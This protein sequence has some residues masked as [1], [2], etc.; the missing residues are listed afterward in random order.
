VQDKVPDGPPSDEQIMER[1]GRLTTEDGNSLVKGHQRQMLA[2]IK[3]LWDKKVGEPRKERIAESLS[4]WNLTGI[5]PKRFERPKVLLET[6][7]VEP[8]E[9]PSEIEQVRQAEI[10]EH[11]PEQR[12]E[13]GLTSEGPRA[14]PGF[15]RGQEMTERM[16]ARTWQQALEQGGVIWAQLGGKLRWWYGDVEHSELF[17]DMRIPR[18]KQ[19]EVPRGRVSAAGTAQT[20]ETTVKL[21]H[22]GHEEF[23]PEEVVRNLRGKLGEGYTFRDVPEPGLRDVWKGFEDVD[24]QAKAGEAAVRASIPDSEHELLESNPVG[25]IGVRTRRVGIK[26]SKAEMDRLVQGAGGLTYRP[27]ALG[28]VLNKLNLLLGLTSKEHG[29]FLRELREQP[30]HVY[31]PK[32]TPEE[33]EGQDEGVYESAVAA[34]RDT[35]YHEGLHVDFYHVDTA[36]TLVR[37]TRAALGDVAQRLKRFEVYRN[38]SE[39][40]MNEEAFVHVATAI[41]TGNV[42]GLSEYVRMDGTPE[43]LFAAVHGVAEDLREA[44]KWEADDNMPARV[45]SRK[46]DDL[47][48]RTDIRQNQHYE[49]KMA[50]NDE[51]AEH[52]YDPNVD[53]WFRKTPQ[54][55]QAER[56]LKALFDQT[57]EN[58]RAHDY[59]PSASNWAEARGVRGPIN[60]RNSGPVKEPENVD[61]PFEAIN[62][63]RE[64]IEPEGPE[65][66]EGPRAAPRPPDQP[67][68]PPKTRW[69]GWTA[70]SSLFRPTGPWVADLDKAVNTALSKHGMKIPIFDRFKDVDEARA[71]RDRWLEP[72]YDRVASILK[73][74]T[75]QQQYAYFEV[76][77]HP[78]QFHAQVGAKLGLAVEDMQRVKL[79]DDWME[80]LQNEQ[81][82]IRIKAYLRDQLPRLRG[83]NYDLDRVYGPAGKDPSKMST[84][85]RLIRKER[86]DPKSRHIGNLIDRALNEAGDQKFMNKPMAAF[87][88]MIDQTAKNEQYVLGS[89]RPPLENYYNYMKNVPDYTGQVMNKAVNDFLEF[90]GPRLAKANK[91]LPHYAQ[92][93][94]NAEEFGGSRSVI[95]KI[96][97]LSYASGL[98]LR[99][100]VPI[101][102]TL[103]VFM[104][105]LPVL[106]PMRF[107]RGM[108]RG[109]TKEGWAFANEQGGLLGRHT[110]GDLYG[111][112]F[113]EIPAGSSNDRVTRF[114]NKLLA[115]SRWGHNIAR[116]IV[117]N[118]E[119]E[120]ALEGVNAVRNGKMTF[121]ELVKQRNSSLWWTDEAFQNR[122]KGQI[123]DRGMSPEAIARNISLETLDLTL[124]PYR[125]GMQPLLLRTGAGRIFGQFG[126]WPMNYWDF[127]QRGAR[128]FGSHPDAALRAVA[129]WSA[130]NYAATS[131][132]NGMGADQGKW[133]W[134]SP[135]GMDMSPHAKLIENMMI[136]MKDSPEG[137]DA[138]RQVLEYPL[139]FLPAGVAGANMLKAAEGNEPFFDMNGH[140]TP[141]FL[142]VL[143]FTPLKEE[144]YRD[145]EDQLLYD[146]GMTRTAAGDIVPTMT[147][148]ER[149]P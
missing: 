107:A 112:I 130:V 146:V 79:L 1:L 64:P 99:P 39:A 29:E 43:D 60:E 122:I 113:N 51:L 65:G 36:L 37:S 105:G 125:R 76:L 129:T 58:E 26:V 138:K 44:T 61:S 50:L 133:F 8:R 68:E 59:M 123:A 32:P 144:P 121:D 87:K 102:D 34:W 62:G 108:I 52:Y 127:L 91:Y 33:F 24:W 89:A 132:M 21:Q 35:Q 103:Q 134:F 114:A 71:A 93:P 7:H 27:G 81:P 143:G 45:L 135:A 69:S 74:S 97:V 25:Q 2:D 139:N 55:I 47:L 18:S 96:M 72:H 149:R 82:S 23:T 111:D 30:T 116:S 85:E 110:I 73:G 98:G 3:M 56:D 106:G 53:M 77:M 104:T 41:R 12:F 94:T 49:L 16:S 136:M 54:R 84:F 75:K 40:A 28:K 90:L 88:R 119:Y 126:M 9:E 13:E 92:L 5:I 57:A 48:R 86:L 11:E 141:S 4:N 95:N 145:L 78:P 109:M 22:Y 124:W 70:I 80:D 42:V 137:R 15:R 14:K 31:T 100:A 17:D 118:G 140:A 115:P 101:R 6:E 142:R 147:H 19:H 128:K 63:T 46:M 10:A 120:S 117:F 38:D 83:S 67:S 66:P 131:A 20:G 148:T